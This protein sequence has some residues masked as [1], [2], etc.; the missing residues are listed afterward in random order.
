MPK[1]GSA[2]DLAF[3]AP[4]IGAKLH[5][6]LYGQIRSAILDGERSYRR[7]ARAPSACAATIAAASASGACHARSVGHDSRE[8]SKR[9]GPPGVGLL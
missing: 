2:L 8:K 7:D 3:E 1:R 4:A 5:Q 9:I 6:W